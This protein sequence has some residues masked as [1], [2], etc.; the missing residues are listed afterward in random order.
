VVGHE[1]CSGYRQVGSDNLLS[2]EDSHSGL[3]S[4]VLL[5]ADIAAGTVVGH[6]QAGPDYAQSAGV[7]RDLSSVAFLT[8]D[9]AADSVVDKG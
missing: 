8:V 5:L 4:V 9:I 7:T 2:A 1:N 3:S 6:E